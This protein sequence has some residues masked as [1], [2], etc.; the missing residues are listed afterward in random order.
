MNEDM[1]RADR[2]LIK[3][4]REYDE[5]KDQGGHKFSTIITEL[6][7]RVGSTNLSLIEKWIAEQ[8]T[9]Y[10]LNSS[11]DEKQ[12]IKDALARTT[13]P[14]DKAFL[15]RLLRYNTEPPQSTSE[16]PSH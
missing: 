7:R 1:P 8:E 6:S 11:G 14:D 13:N 5:D 9:R 2:E 10:G 3:Q 16:Y 12:N 15:E 4:Y